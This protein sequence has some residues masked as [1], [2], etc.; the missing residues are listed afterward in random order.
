MSSGLFY[1]NLFSFL[2]SLNVPSALKHAVYSR[3]KCIII[4]ACLSLYLF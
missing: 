3:F 1:C 4:G 2:V